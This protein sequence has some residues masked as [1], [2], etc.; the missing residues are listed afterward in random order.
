MPELNKEGPPADTIEENGAWS[1]AVAY[2]Q[3]PP[4]RKNYEKSSTL[5]GTNV[6]FCT[7][8]VSICD[9]VSLIC[10][11]LPSLPAPVGLPYQVAPAGDQ[12]VLDWSLETLSSLGLKA[13]VGFSKREK[14]TRRVKRENGTN[15]IITMCSKNPQ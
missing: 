7:N 9:I 10:S 8:I 15:A 1:T 3:A 2:P 11:H 4:T 13:E 6:I 5:S 12:L 14:R